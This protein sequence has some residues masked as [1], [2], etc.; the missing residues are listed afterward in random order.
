M[1][2]ILNPARRSA[3]YFIIVC[4]LLWFVFPDGKTIAAGLL[5][6]C[7]VSLMN[8]LLLRRRIELISLYLSG[9]Y[10]RR[11]G[12]GMGIRFASV[13]LAAMVAH[14]YPA[15]FNLPSTLVSSFYVSIAV[16][17]TAFVRNVRK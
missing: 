1:D 7:F 17:V 3:F 11:V 4:V 15:I 2:D 12:L 6:G 10:H 9:Q 8:A 5:L 16:Y 13:L 14:K